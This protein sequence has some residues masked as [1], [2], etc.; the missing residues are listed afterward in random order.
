MTVPSRSRK[1]ARAPRDMD[2][3]PLELAARGLRRGSV[4]RTATPSEAK[5]KGATGWPP[6]NAFS[7][8][9]PAA[10]P[11]AIGTRVGPVL[12]RAEVTS[13]GADP[14]HIPHY[15]P[16]FEHSCRSGATPATQDYAGW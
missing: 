2:H 14:W 13:L 10:N 5:E 11:C 3:L 7:G 8:R 12:G 15:G 4:K 9:R 1:T 16:K 6:R